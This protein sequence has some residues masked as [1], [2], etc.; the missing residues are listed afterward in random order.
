MEKEGVEPTA[1]VNQRSQRSRQPPLSCDPRHHDCHPLSALLP[2]ICDRRFRRWFSAWVLSQARRTPIASEIAL[3]CQ[4]RQRALEL[5]QRDQRRVWF[6]LWF[7]AFR[8]AVAS[9]L[10][11]KGPALSAHCCA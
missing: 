5:D 10:V 6:C 11:G 7:P 8:Q 3:Q 1:E 4:G 2:V 9:P